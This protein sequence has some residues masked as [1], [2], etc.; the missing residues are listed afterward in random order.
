MKSARFLS[1]LAIVSVAAPVQAQPIRPFS[2]A[3]LRSAQAANKPVLV[4]AFASWCPTCR[5]Q[6]PVLDALSTDPHYRDLVILRLD[7]DKQASEKKV[8]GITKQST[9]I[10]YKG[11]RE[12]GRIVGITDAR[13]L[14]AFAAAPLR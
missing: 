3:A 9:L 1:L 7:Y 2:I 13:Q 6:A 10:S 14:K 5:A 4:D 8:L 11:S 12:V